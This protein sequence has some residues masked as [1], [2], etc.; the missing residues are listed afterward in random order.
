LESHA[1]LCS[2]L[3]TNYNFSLAKSNKQQPNPT[4]S[5][6]YSSFLNQFQSKVQMDLLLIHSNSW[7]LILFQLYCCI[8]SR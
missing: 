3:S 8:K 1:L 6:L 5:S 2:N 4:L 7:S